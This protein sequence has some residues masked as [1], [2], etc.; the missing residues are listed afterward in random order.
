MHDTSTITDDLPLRA[1]LLHL[2]HPF[3]VLLLSLPNH[4]VNG[5]QHVML[6]KQHGSQRRYLRA[7]TQR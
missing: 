4:T 5:H 1:L 3:A 7:W 6:L 2:L